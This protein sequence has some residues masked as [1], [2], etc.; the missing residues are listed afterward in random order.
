MKKRYDTIN[1]LMT[2]MG[3]LNQTSRYFNI[4]I[5]DLGDK[6]RLGNVLF[7]NFKHQ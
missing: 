1:S 6:Y 2:I 7:M 5:F 3:L 4:Q